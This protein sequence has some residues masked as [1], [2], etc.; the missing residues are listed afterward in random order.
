VRRIAQ[1]ARR[2][3]RRLLAGKGAQPR[4]LPSCAPRDPAVVSTRL[5][6]RSRCSPVAVIAVEEGSG[7]AGRV[8][9]EVT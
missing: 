9:G 7:F 8:P 4:E 6:H 1:P 5:L 3:R 2:R